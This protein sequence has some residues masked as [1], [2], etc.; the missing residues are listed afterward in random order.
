MSACSC[1]DAPEAPAPEDGSQSPEEAP[2]PSESSCPIQASS[3]AAGSAFLKLGH[4]QETHRRSGQSQSLLTLDGR[5]VA[6][7]VV[8]RKTEVPQP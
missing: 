4:P 1:F 6:Q 2:S 7:V 8:L 3:G 5:E